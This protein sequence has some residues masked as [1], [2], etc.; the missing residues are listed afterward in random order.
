MS[1][2]VQF[3]FTPI[4]VVRVGSGQVVATSDVVAAG[5]ALEAT[6]PEPQPV[7]PLKIHPP[8]VSPS[9]QGISPKHV[10]R[11]AKQRVR[12]IKQELKRMRALQRELAQ[13]ENLLSAAKKPLHLAEVRQLANRK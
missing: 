3:E 8:G 10:I 2:A 5:A 1:E 11:A 12:E 7:P 6:R 4:G 9:A 13:L